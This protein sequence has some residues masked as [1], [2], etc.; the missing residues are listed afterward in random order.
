MARDHAVVDL[1]P[2]VAPPA[3]QVGDGAVVE[4][5][6]PV[7]MVD[8]REA[9]SPPDLIDHLLPVGVR[10][11]ELS[12]VHVLDVDAARGDLVCG[13]EHHPPVRPHLERALIGEVIVVG[14]REEPVGALGVGVDDLL[15]LEHAVAQRRVSV[16]VPPESKPRLREVGVRV[17]YPRHPLCLPQACNVTR[18]SPPRQA[19]GG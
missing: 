19:S 6:L 17:C 10:R 4:A 7:R 5:L 9:A 3:L 18:R 2:R 13:D 1:H 12:R 15:R 11:D 14:D 8:H 16:K